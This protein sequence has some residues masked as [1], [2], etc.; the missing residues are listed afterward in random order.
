MPFCPPPSIVH[1]FTLL[2]QDG[3]NLPN[4]CVVLLILQVQYVIDH[5]AHRE[6]LKPL[7]DE[8]EQE[9]EEG[10]EGKGGGDTPPPRRV[11]VVGA[12]AAGLAAASTLKVM[13]GTAGCD[14]DVLALESECW[15]FSEREA[16]VIRCRCQ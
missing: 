4:T 6:G 9:E 5:M 13:H 10:E 16:S 7:A 15:V 1:T 14:V 8:G 2:E 12:G 3:V 11:L